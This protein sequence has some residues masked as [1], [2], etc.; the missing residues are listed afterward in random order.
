MKG[1]ICLLL[2]IIACHSCVNEKTHVNQIIDEIS[3]YDNQV[4]DTSSS[5]DV[6]NK[7]SLHETIKEH[8]FNSIKDLGKLLGFLKSK[9]PGQMDMQIVAEKAKKNLQ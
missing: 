3:I 8:G 5:I 4:K 2:Y 6:D 1:R 7:K 9:Y